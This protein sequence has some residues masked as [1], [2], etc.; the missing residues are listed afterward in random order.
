MPDVWRASVFYAGLEVGGDF[1]PE[2]GRRH[3]EDFDGDQDG[4]D[5]G[6]A[7]LELQ[8]ENN[9]EVVHNGVFL[10]VPASMIACTKLTFVPEPVT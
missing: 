4:K 2:V 1:P 6:I 8:R 3:V 10:V 7:W 9:W 5:A